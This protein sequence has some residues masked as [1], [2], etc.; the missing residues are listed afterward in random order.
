M[1]SSVIR[2]LGFFAIVKTDSQIKN[3]FPKKSLR[4]RGKAHFPFKWKITAQKWVFSLVISENKS[5]AGE[6]EIIQPSLSK[7]GGSC[8]RRIQTQE[9]SVT[10]QS[11]SKCFPLLAIR[12]RS[13]EKL[14]LTL[15]V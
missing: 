8:W 7:K 14:C 15:L 2:L 5:S 11:L 4:T 1:D 13:R 9:N 12:S 6:I 10:R 3:S